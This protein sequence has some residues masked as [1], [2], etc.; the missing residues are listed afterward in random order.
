MVAQ[1]PLSIGSSLGSDEDICEETV[2]AGLQAPHRKRP[3]GLLAVAFV[4]SY[5]HLKEER[6]TFVGDSMRSVVI[7]SLCMRALEG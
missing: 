6:T 3:E 7:Q 1:P 5:C 4:A 2:R